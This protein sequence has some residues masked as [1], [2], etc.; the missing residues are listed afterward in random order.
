MNNDLNF[1][2]PG[3]AATTITVNAISANGHTFLASMFG[4]GAVSV[5]LPKTTAG[6]FS[7]FATRKGLSCEWV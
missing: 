4:A 2:N 1:T 3:F 6:N 5:E 7:V